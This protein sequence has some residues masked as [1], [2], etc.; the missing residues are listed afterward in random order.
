MHP[1]I[2]V[3]LGMFYRAKSDFYKGSVFELLDRAGG[4]DEDHDVM[5]ELSAVQAQWEF[6][7]TKS[8]G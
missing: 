6:E 8:K 2:E 7:R 1:E 3:F 4:T 5:F